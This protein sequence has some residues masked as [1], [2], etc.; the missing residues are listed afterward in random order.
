[1]PSFAY[2]AATA[3]GKMITGAIDAMDKSG[4]VGR[5]QERGLIPI[6]ISVPGQSGSKFS[7][8]LAGF[9]AGRGMAKHRQMFARTLASMLQ[10]GVPLDRSLAVSTELCESPLLRSTL[11]QVLRAVKG[12]KSLSAGMESHP[13][14]FP[15]FYVSMVRAGEAGGNTAQVFAQLADYQESVNELR[16]QVTSALIYPA[17]LTIVGGFSVLIMLEF[18]VPKFGAVFQQAGATL[19]LP[20]QIL[21]TISDFIRATWWGWLVGIPAIAWMIAHWLRTDS[22]R[23]K[24]DHWVMRIPRIGS[25]VERVLVTRFARSLGTLLMGGVPM[26]RSLEIAGE[27]VD[28]RK[29]ENAV[30]AAAKGVKQGKG[31][32]RPL[33]E[34][35]AFPPLSIHLL[36]VG[37]ETGRLDAMLL[38]VAEV[39]ERETRTAIKNMVALFEPLMILVMGVVVGS[40][41]I[42]ILLAIFSINDIPL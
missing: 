6:S 21:L 28:N 15:S 38:Q 41:V 32:T 14:V 31:L 17:L 39:Y 42:S 37:E 40:I 2:Q 16:S 19:P 7:A 12:G 4:A 23:N 24:W 29:I 10:A 8:K 36:G 1:V 33:G 27:V 11:Q 5:L 22:G 34:T 35:G 20:T 25:V 26:I 9:F 30:A 13:Q 3:D 18:V